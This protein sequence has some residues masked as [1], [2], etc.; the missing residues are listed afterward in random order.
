MKSRTLEYFISFT[1][2][3]K[4]SYL[5]TGIVAND[6]KQSGATP[7]SSKATHHQVATC[8]SVANGVMLP[9]GLPYGTVI[10]IRNDGAYT[11]YVHHPVVG[12]IINALPATVAASAVGAYQVAPGY[13]VDFIIAGD[14][15][16][17]SFMNNSPAVIP[18][19]AAYTVLPCSNGSVFTC[20]KLGGA[21]YTI[22]LPSPTIAGLSYKFIAG[23]T[24]ARVIF[25]TSTAAN[26]VGSVNI[27]V[28]ASANA[29]VAVPSTSIQF[30]ATSVP[31]DYCILTSD[32]T[33]WNCS[34]ATS[35]AAGMAFT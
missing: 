20:T 11:L 17:Y 6:F 16:A 12:G 14:T 18:I 33:N 10:K 9:T 22:T 34:G 19:A 7:L 8:T 24:V 35:V 31:G 13:V 21:N 15:Q 1:I 23:P 26:I 4:M 29:L 25:M 27:N 30:T 32:G 3:Y 5:S 28:N 2:I